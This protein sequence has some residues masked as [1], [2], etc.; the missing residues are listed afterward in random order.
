MFIHKPRT[1][2]LTEGRCHASVH[3]RDGRS[4]TTYQCNRKS[5]V[6][7]VYDGSLHWFCHQHDPVKV[8]ERRKA[9]QAK[10]EEQLKQRV[11]PYDKAN[12]YE[13]VLN[14]IANIEHGN[15]DAKMLAAKALAKFK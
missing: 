3:D 1:G 5:A 6:Q 11:L 2:K 15:L 8:A 13:H 12:H 9:S 14:R 7:R 10:Y 4:F